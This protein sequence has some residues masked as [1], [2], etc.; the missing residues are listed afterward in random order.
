MVQKVVSFLFSCLVII[1]IIDPADRLFHLKMPI[2]ALILLVWFMSKLNNS[3]KYK[4]DSILMV[5]GFLII[6]LIGL[7]AAIFQNEDIDYA[8]AIGFFKSLTILFLLFVVIDLNIEADKFLNKYS[9]L[10]PLLTIPIY[11]ISINFPISFAFLYDYLVVEKQ[12]AMIANRQFYGYDILSV[13]Y[14]TSAV[15]VFP[16]SFYSYNFFIKKKGIKNLILIILLFVCLVMSGT[17]AN[18]ISAAIIVLYYLYQYFKIKRNALYTIIGVISIFSALTYFI[19]SLSFAEKE[20]SSEIKSG[21]FTSFIGN[22]GDNP[23]YL[24][25]GQGLGSKS[26]STGTSTFLSQTELTYFDLV[27]F[28]GLPLT[29]IFIFLVIYPLVYLYQNQL[30][31][32]RNKYAVIAFLTYLF[33]AGTNPLLISSTGMLI[34]IVMYSFTNKNIYV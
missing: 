34:L 21:H 32:E 4:I 28:F 3:I 8:F 1:L 26:Y 20:E 10:I 27:R 11:I 19:L 17:R 14:K 22:I 16:L 9:I 15:L 5:V 12:V 2:F 30:I 7:F 13:Y 6:A 31:F 25:W 33:I 23:Q 18:I 29:C 24:L